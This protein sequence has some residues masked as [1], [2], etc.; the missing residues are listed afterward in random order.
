[1]PDAAGALQCLFARLLRRARNLIRRV[2]RRR[3]E[4]ALR[5]PGAFLR[6]TLAGTDP[7]DGPLS[8]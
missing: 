2:L 5:V 1:M 8:I 4:H 7:R 3:V 6:Q